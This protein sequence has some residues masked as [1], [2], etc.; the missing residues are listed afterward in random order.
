ML[1]VEEFVVSRR[2][3][4]HISLDVRFIKKMLRYALYH[5]VCVLS[6][7]L[8]RLVQLLI[9][10]Q[11]LLYF[12]DKIAEIGFSKFAECEDYQFKA[13]RGVFRVLNSRQSSPLFVDMRE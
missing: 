10:D 1:T 5:P 8:G 11:E 7:G 3:S 4:G 12:T 6:D 2:K 9:L 13:D